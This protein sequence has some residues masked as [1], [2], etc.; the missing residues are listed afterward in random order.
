MHALKGVRI[1]QSMLIAITGGIGCGKSVVSALLCVMGYPVYDC[2]KGAKWVME[3]D[4]QL[5]SELVALFG[6][7]TYLADGHLNKLYLA[8]RIFNDVEALKAMNACVHPAV[9]R[10]MDRFITQH[11]RNLITT[12]PFFFES[13]ILFE[14]GFDKLSNPDKVWTVT[15]PL[16]LRIERAMVRDNATRDQIVARINSQMSQEEKEKRADDI[17]IN[18]SPYSVIEQVRNL[19]SQLYK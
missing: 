6:K 11:S 5:R 16:E 8:S 7:E 15:A 19:L 17:I 13:A 4:L 10:D 14:S 3:N 9:K 2:D 1:I 18:A 12:R